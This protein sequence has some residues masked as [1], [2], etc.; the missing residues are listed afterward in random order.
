MS[1]VARCRME[2]EAGDDGDIA[3]GRP[4]RR[5]ER[6]EAMRAFGKNKTRGLAPLG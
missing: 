4:S 2:F 5:I 6:E 3:Y 1:D